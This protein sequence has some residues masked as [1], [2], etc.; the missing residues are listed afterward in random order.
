MPKYKKFSAELTS[1]VRDKVISLD[2]F[3]ETSGIHELNWSK[4]NIQSGRFRRDSLFL[5]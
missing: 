5:R 4:V 1:E 2:F 3:R